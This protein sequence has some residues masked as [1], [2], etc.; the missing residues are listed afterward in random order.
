MY[1]GEALAGQRSSLHSSSV[2][3]AVSCDGC[4]YQAAAF[5]GNI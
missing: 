2:A 5:G 3:R 1:E 4:V